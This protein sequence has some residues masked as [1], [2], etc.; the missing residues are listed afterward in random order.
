MADALH[1]TVILQPVG[2]FKWGW[3]FIEFVDI[4][5]M[6]LSL[7]KFPCSILI[8]FCLFPLFRTNPICHGG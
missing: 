5:V 6:T 8:Y 1:C 2:V 7:M 4:F 3:L